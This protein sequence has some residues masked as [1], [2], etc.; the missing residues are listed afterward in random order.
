MSQFP[1]NSGRFPV[2]RMRRLRYHPLVRELVSQV[3]IHPKKLIYPLFVRPGQGIRQPI[4][5]MPG[6]FQFSPDELL[7]EIREL[8]PLG[9]GGIL[10][11]GIP[12]HK[13]AIGSDAT[14]EHGIIA[15][16][17]KAIRLEKLN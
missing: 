3:E 12:E 8:M 6:L 5:S 10:L 14:S 1:M 7:K 17:V 4:S 11:F 13:D 9:L 2:I 16:T 15:E